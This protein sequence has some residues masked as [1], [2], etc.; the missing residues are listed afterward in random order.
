MSFRS[1]EKR[2]DANADYVKQYLK[3][4]EGVGKR[5]GNSS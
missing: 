3:D 2:K 4:V 1:T 5:R